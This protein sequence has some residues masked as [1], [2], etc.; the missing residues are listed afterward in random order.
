MPVQLHLTLETHVVITS[1][2]DTLEVAWEVLAKE[3]ERVLKA[4]PRLGKIVPVWANLIDQSV[5]LLGGRVLSGRSSKGFVISE[6]KL[7]APQF[8]AIFIRSS[9]RMIGFGEFNAS[10]LRLTILCICSRRDVDWI[11]FGGILTCALLW[12]AAETWRMNVRK[13]RRFEQRATLDVQESVR[14]FEADSI[15]TKEFVDFLTIVEEASNISRGKLRPGDRP[16]VELCPE[17]GWEFDDGINLLTLALYRR[18]GGEESTFVWDE[19]T[20][21]QD[22]LRRVKS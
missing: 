1:M 12:L 6:Q 11:I 10:G 21:L 15:S 19:S 5:S 17:R 20:S 16:A 4:T 7:L 8:A 3:A 9:I 13:S 18:F 2:A 14:E 22:L